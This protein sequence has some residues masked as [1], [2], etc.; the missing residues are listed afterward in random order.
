MQQPELFRLMFRP[1][2]LESSKNCDPPQQLVGGFAVLLEGLVTGQ[3]MGLI[4]TGDPMLLA[5]TAWSTVHGLA[6][7]LLDGAA[8]RLVQS[9]EEAAALAE[10]ITLV[11]HAGL[12]ARER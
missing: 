5:L 3:A 7:L 1:E 10:K 2:L 8:G 12:L 6:T 9:T 4:T 11:L